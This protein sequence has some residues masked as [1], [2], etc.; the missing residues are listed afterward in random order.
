MTHKSFKQQLP[1][2]LIMNIISFVIN[3]GVGLW[4][5]PYL[6]RYLGQA[7]YG[8]VPLAMM[9]T[10]YISLITI[11]INGTITRFLTID[12]QNDDWEKANKTFNTAFFA[13]IILIILQII[14]LGFI[15]FNLKD[16]I[17][18]PHGILQDTYYLFVFTF[19]GYLLSLLS[20]VFTT[21]MYTYNR[22]DLL[23][24]V[25]ITRI[26]IRI[27]AIVLFF[28]LIK[29][30]LL[31]VGVGNFLGALFSLIFSFTY[32]KKLTPKLKININQFN[33]SLLRRL[34][35]MGGWL[36]LNQVG[37]LLFLKIDLLVINK[38]L[39][40][41]KGGEYAAVQQWSILLR[42]FAGVLSGMV[43][44]MILI[45]YA[46]KRI[47]SVISYGK[48][49]VKYLS[50]FIG[51]IVG[52]ISG[53]SYPL[54]SLWLGND[55]SQYTGLLILTLSTLVVNLG[56]LPL[57]SINTALNKVKIPGIVSLAM[58]IINIILVIIFIVKFNLGLVGV[59]LAAA[60]VL[61][62]KNGL[63]T[64]WYTAKILHI[65]LTAFYKPLGTGV[66]I[67]ISSFIMSY[68]MSFM[69]HSW[70]NLILFGVAISVVSIIIFWFLLLNKTE[71]VL[72]LSMLP[73]VIQK[74]IG[75]KK[76]FNF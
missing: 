11:S 70:L 71:R 13:L 31:F 21:S 47:Q 75:K 32:W 3:I 4:L 58:G 67:S 22:L 35:S 65:R 64:P 72:M 30:T 1:Q 28:T 56:V 54:L 66:I 69:V 15:I 18:I 62:L 51:V 20:S 48:L 43:G 76:L 8:L 63:F 38:F 23:K 29:P 61:T 53:F 74:R 37:Y 60:I 16:I 24:S 33:R 73:N 26:S 55:F 10:E 36:V 27:I 2:N 44:P 59:A 5:V 41:Q 52:L 12:V 68:Y 50:V 9:F 42:V 39:G 40:P 19:A 14:A 17:N 25:D 46:N 7:A 57:F 6:I 34:F 45:S 49:G